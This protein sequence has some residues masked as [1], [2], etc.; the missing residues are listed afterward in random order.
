MA[1]NACAE[2][3]ELG[4]EVVRIEVDADEFLAWCREQGRPADSGERAHFAAEKLRLRALAGKPGG[5][6]GWEA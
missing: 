1:T 4:V 6:T 5:H 3:L 2:L